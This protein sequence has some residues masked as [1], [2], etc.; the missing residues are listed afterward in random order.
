MKY[1]LPCPAC[2]SRLP[3]ETG[4]AGQTIRC[5]CGSS[6]E[7]PSIRG[8]RALEPLAD[9]RPVAASW[10]RRKGLLFLGAAMSIGALVAA[11]AVLAL[12]PAVNDDGGFRIQVDEEAI[13]SEVAAL[14]PVDSIERF[15]MADAAL[16]TTFAEQKPDE[17]PVHLQP[18][19]GLLISFER[20]GSILARE[21]A[22][23]VMRQVAQRNEQR[24][25]RENKRK[26]MNDW[27]VFI[28]IVFVVG[29][30]TAGSALA[31]GE[32]KPRRRQLAQSPAARTRAK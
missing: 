21:G 22:A 6:V 18:S 10:T 3:V 25:T 7:V 5:S 32:R 31:V 1:L 27:L 17:V 4:Q 20:P 9:E 13:H 11:A 28:G 14:P 29:I 30:L 19:L 15:Q 24:Q 2:N 12:R 26:A 23:A 16:P 8:L